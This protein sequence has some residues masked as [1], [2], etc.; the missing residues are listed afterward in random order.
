MMRNPRGLVAAA[1]T[2]A[3]LATL[4]SGPAQAV[5]ASE[6]SAQSVRRASIACFEPKKAKTNYSWGDGKLTV[7]VYFNNHCS[8]RVGAKLHIRNP[9]TGNYTECLVTNGGTKG[10]KKFHI[11]ATSSLTKI[12]NGC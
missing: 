7:T 8:H 5:T 12:T 3:A 11:G 9:A 6:T 10:R 1:V 4:S 2:A